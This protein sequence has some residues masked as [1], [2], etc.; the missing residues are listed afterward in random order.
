MTLTP[1]QRSQLLRR[2]RSGDSIAHLARWYGLHPRVI[3]AIV[4]QEHLA[5]LEESA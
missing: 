1:L 2:W 3:A 5:R 4:R